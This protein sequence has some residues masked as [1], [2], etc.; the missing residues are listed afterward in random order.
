[1]NTGIVIPARIKSSRFPNKMLAELNG[2]PLIKHVYDKCAS[3]GFE[4]VVLT[5]SEEIAEIVPSRMTTDADNGTERCAQKAIELGWDY[6]INVQGDMPDITTEIIVE[7]AKNCK[8][9]HVLTAY[10]DMNSV[11]RANPDSV[12]LIHNGSKAKWFCRASLDYGDHHLGV[13]AYSRVA[14]LEY[15]NL[16]KTKE[17]EIEKL[18]QL[19]WLQNNI[20][21]GIV[22]VDFDGI[23]INTPED[24]EK[25]HKQN[26]H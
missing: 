9:H 11:D 14:L 1:M 22:K 26:S 20:D 18:E 25:W 15:P 4:T 6:F 13:Y 3:V 10:T 8:D 17:E 7:L 12:K 2:I 23:E 21:I 5:D 24:L 16:I 19:R